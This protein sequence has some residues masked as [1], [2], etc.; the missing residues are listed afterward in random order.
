MNKVALPAA[1]VFEDAEEV[2]GK[3]GYVT[4]EGNQLSIQVGD[5]P[6]FTL[7]EELSLTVLPE[8]TFATRGNR[9]VM[10]EEE[11]R[12][13][14]LKWN[15]DRAQPKTPALRYATKWGRACKAAAANAGN[16]VI[17]VEYESGEHLVDLT[18]S[19]VTVTSGTDVSESEDAFTSYLDIK[20][21]E[22]RH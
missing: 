13:V 21:N 8:F 6:S 5:R 1:R 4:G 12:V 9:E 20:N 2:L 18:W 16:G 15:P 14:E 11:S 10:F 3:R 17:T 19:L 7:D 22:V